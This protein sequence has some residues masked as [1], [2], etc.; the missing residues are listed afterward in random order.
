MKHPKHHVELA[1]KRAAYRHYLKNQGLCTP[2]VISN[3]WT[4]IKAKRLAL[5]ARPGCMKYGI[6]ADLLVA[7][8]LR[9]KRTHFGKN[10]EQS[11][12]IPIFLKNTQKDFFFYLHETI[13][14]R[15]E[16]IHHQC[17]EFFAEVFVRS[18]FKE[19]GFVFRDY[20]VLA[21]KHSPFES[22]YIREYEYST[23][24]GFPYRFNMNYHHG[25]ISISIVNTKEWQNTETNKFLFWAD[26][27]FVS[28]MLDGNRTISLVKN[29][30][31]PP[32]LDMPLKDFRE[33]L[34]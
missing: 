19:R 10:V 15:G 25:A 29:R 14:S 11:Q 26:I 31:G 24:P 1:R 12:Y 32:W 2:A 20:T 13:L 23:H 30:T 9:H 16:F 3:E 4:G 22:I 6:T 28:K 8:V 18:W 27:C 33:R 21:K 34:I 7:H 17:N 5:L